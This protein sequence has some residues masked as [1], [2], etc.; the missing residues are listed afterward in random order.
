MKKNT[1]LF[2]LL[3]LLP[4]FIFG[5]WVSDPMLN[6]AI[7]DASGEQAIPKIGTTADGTT[8]IAWFS[9]ESGNYDVYLQKL[10]AAGN[11]LWADDGLLVSD[12]PAMTWLT[13]WDMAVDQ[14][15]CAILTF[16]DIRNVD[17]DA[18]AYRISPTGEFLW[19]DDGIELSTGPAFDAAPKVTV[20]NAGNAVLAW[21]AD[22]VIIMQK[23]SPDGT[24]L[25]G[26]NGITLSTANTL[27]WPQLMPVGTDDVIMKYFEDSGPTWAPTRHVYAQR[28]DADGSPVWTSPAIVSNAGGISAWTQIFSFINDGND[29]FFIA[30]HDDRDNNSLA[31]IFV[32]HI[33]ADGTVVFADDGVEASTMPSRNHFYPFLSL[34]PGTAEV[35]VM[36]NEM[37]GDQNNRGIYGQKFSDTGNRLWGDNG[38]TFIEI[39]PTNV[40]PFAQEISDQ[41][42]VLFYEQ[43]FT[44]AAAAVK[45]MRVDANGD[46]VWANDM[47]TLC[48]VQSSKVHPVVSSFTQGQWISAWEDDRNASTDIY[49]QNIQLDGSL[50]PVIIPSNL[51]IIPDTLTIDEFLPYSG[52]AINETNDPIIVDDVYFNSGDF[53]MYYNSPPELPTTLAPGDSLQIE[54][55]VI[56]GSTFYNPDGYLYDG[57]VIESEVG[58]YHITV[59]INTDLLGGIAEDSGYLDLKIYPNPAKT[60]ANFEFPSAQYGQSELQI[61]NVEGKLLRSLQFQPVKELKWDLKDDNGNKLAPGN[62]IYHIT[63]DYWTVSGKISIGK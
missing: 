14:E 62:Y 5:Q 63:S 11:K 22:D 16:Q 42:F 2:S 18:F 19:G 44:A 45:A 8:Y 41:D 13:D 26:D 40:Y 12:H 54:I 33:D 39:S 1:M 34:I 38:K 29:G 36:W 4:V 23:I 30:W 15:G 28:Y 25:W 57:I 9:N 7:A 48:S 20:T 35:I 17:N 52:Y 61:L 56:P 55:I 6:T 47:I 60:F 51:T 10:D 3:T 50:G 49:G 53:I 58:T 37:D 32:Q 43:D 21:Q 24:K 59:A 27:S 46:Y 31:S